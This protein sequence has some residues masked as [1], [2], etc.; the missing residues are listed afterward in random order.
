MIVQCDCLPGL[1]TEL[2]FGYRQNVP[3]DSL[4]DGDGVLI[5]NNPGWF[6]GNNPFCFY[7]SIDWLQTVHALCVGRKKKALHI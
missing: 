7:Q 2:C 1:V 6:N 3:D 4:I 5:E